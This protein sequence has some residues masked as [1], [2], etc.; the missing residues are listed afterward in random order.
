[1]AGKEAEEETPTGDHRQ[2][3]TAPLPVVLVPV[4]QCRLDHLTKRKKP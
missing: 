3:L 2:D 4:V 1:M